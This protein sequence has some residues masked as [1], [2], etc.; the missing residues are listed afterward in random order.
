MGLLSELLGHACRT[1]GKKCND[2][3]G[4]NVASFPA[5][6]RDTANLVSAVESHNY[7][8]INRPPHEPLHRSQ[9]PSKSLRR[10][11]QRKSM[12]T[13]ASILGFRLTAWPAPKNLI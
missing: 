3:G 13:T 10:W 4:T 2:L 1:L 7:R 8:G 5:K 9:N 12:V 6:M 11:P